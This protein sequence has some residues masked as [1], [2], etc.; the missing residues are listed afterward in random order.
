MP[1]YGGKLF[2]E[3]KGVQAKM[4]HEMTDEEIE[5]NIQMNMPSL[6]TVCTHDRPIKV[7]AKYMLLCGEIF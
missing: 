2:N 7:I 5:M 1:L 6:R 3:Y 4:F